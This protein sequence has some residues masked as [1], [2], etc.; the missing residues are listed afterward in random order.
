MSLQLE[1]Q[2]WK[3]LEIISGKYLFQTYVY[4]FRILHKE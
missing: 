4:V 3:I 2:I 1:N